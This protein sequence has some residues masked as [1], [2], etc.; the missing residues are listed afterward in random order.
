MGTLVRVER[1]RAGTR[2]RQII[3]RAPGNRRGWGIARRRQ[4]SRASQRVACSDGPG[5]AGRGDAIEPDRGA[6]VEVAR[7]HE[8]RV[9]GRDGTQSDPQPV[10][11]S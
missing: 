11:Q 10:V 3:A 2:I 4:T 7:H 9:A 6:G 5:V 1:L 8:R